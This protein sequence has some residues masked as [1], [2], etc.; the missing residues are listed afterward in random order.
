[1]RVI[2]LA[3]CSLLGTLGIS[4]EKVIH[5]CTEMP[6]GTLAFR[7]AQRQI[8]EAA[9]RA[10]SYKPKYGLYWTNGSTITVRFLDGSAYVRNKVKQYAN[11]WTQ[12]AN[13]N[14]KFV[15]YG[16]ADIR[17]SFVLNGSSWSV[18]GKQALQ[19]PQNEATMNFG[20][21]DESTP[22]YE[23]RRTILHEFGH[24]LGLLHE[25]Q[26]PSGGIPWD[27]EAVYEHYRRTQ[28]WNERT[29]Y[30]NVI[31]KVN[32]NYTQYSQYDPQ[33]IMHYPVSAS[34]TNGQYQVGMNERLSSIDI[35][36]ISEV[37]P[38]RSN[39]SNP[40]TRPSDP[41]VTTPTKPVE[42]RFAVTVSN[43][44]GENQ[45]KETI[46]LTLGGQKY[47]FRLSQD[48][49]RQQAIQFRMKKG[50]YNY[51]LSSA[52]TYQFSRKVWN[53][54]KYVRKNVERTIY[55]DGTG[56]LNVTGGGTYTLYGDYDKNTQRM[57]VYLGEV[58]PNSSLANVRAE[59]CRN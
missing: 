3:L 21:L 5:T 34:L 50:R 23:F 9:S 55:G 22:E 20:W 51:R 53:G 26:N 40:P 16:Q 18:I 54:W 24:A 42:E 29:T 41:V 4:Q 35:Q 58:E 57:R 33:S 10:V 56:T 8:P 11:Y 59:V 31:Q 25:H 17:V 49:R 46:E 37:Y 19:V 36:F 27:L 48:G 32:R 47:T 14:F 45:V 7:Q 15:N 12:H 28:G 30:H 38:G 39:W 52:S 2:L 44:L 13:L 1:M 43:Q 6:A